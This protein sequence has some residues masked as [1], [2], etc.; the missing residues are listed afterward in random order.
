MKLKN[1]IGLVLHSCLI[2]VC[3]VQL[4]SQTI[5]LH[6]GNLVNVNSGKVEPGMT[7]VVEQKKIREVLHGY[8]DPPASAKLID[9]KDK[10]V[11]PGWIDM[12]VHIESVIERG[13]YINRFTLSESDVAYL[14]ASFGEK[15][16]LAGFT[17]VRELGGTGVNVAYKNA[18]LK[19]LATGPRIYTS[20]K[21]ISST[22]GHGDQTSGAK[23]GIYNAP[24]P[25]SG[26]ADSPDECRKAVRQMLKDGADVIKVTATG[27]VTSLTRDGSRPQ[28]SQEELNA[29][30]ETA[31]DYGVH[32]AAHAHGDE[33]IRRAILAGVTTIEHGSQMTDS[34]MDL[35]VRKGVYYVPTLTAGMSVSDSARIPGFFPEMV[36]VKAIETGRLIRNVFE[37]LVKKGARI[38]FGTD[39]G[40]FPHGKNGLEFQYMHELGMSPM[41]CIR[42]ATVINASILGISDQTGSLE[43]GKFA[44]IVAV[45]GDA[46]RDFN[47][48]QQVRFVMKEGRIYRH[49]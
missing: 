34:T 45:E 12:H 31:R 29:I 48:I 46:M 33:G 6:C 5:Y 38:A 35:L 15:T 7:L 22:G 3:T 14:A 28:F 9:L 25:E 49:D 30:V 32:V 23:K 18:I 20:F 26:V 4:Y 19:G 42:A 47:R 17:T 43:A 11:M 40:V 27:G 37:K 8:V 13:S 39:A 1:T 2:F 36:R 41:D 24:G 10:T 44:D 21:A 16:L